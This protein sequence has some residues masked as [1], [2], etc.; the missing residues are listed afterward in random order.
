MTKRK[1][2]LIGMPWFW[3]YLPS[4]QLAIV[5]DVLGQ[6][7]VEADI[8]EFYADLTEATGIHVYKGIAN[9]SGYI[10]ELLFSQFYYE[11]FDQQ[12][13]D[14]RPDLGFSTKQVQDDIFLFATPVIEKFLGDCYVEADWGQYDCIC[15]S[16]TASQTAASMALAKR[17][18]ATHPSIPIIFGGSSCAGEMGRAMLRMC[19]EVDIVVHAEAEAVVPLL[20]EALSG[21]R[22]M[23]DVAGI[24][25]RE[26][27]AIRTNDKAGLHALSRK[28]GVLDFD[29]YF[30]RVADNKVLSDNGVWVPFESSRGCWYGEK[31][32]CT[33][34]GLNEIIQYRERG[35][36][37]LLDELK[38]YERK[39]GAK[40]FFAVDLIMPLSFFKG[41]LPSV[42]AAGKKWTIFYEIKSNMRRHEIEMLADSG[43]RWIQPGIESLD[44]DILRIMRK[45]VSAAHNIQT[46]R[47]T[48]EK[49]VT[50]SWNLITGFPRETAKSYF[51]MAGMF[52]KLHHLEPPVGLGDFEVHRFSP[53]F[54]N[55]E[56]MGIAL[57]GAYPTY[58]SVYP[59]EPEILDQLVYRFDYQLLAQ[60]DPALMDSKRVIHAAVETWRKAR[61]RG[62]DLHVTYHPDGTATLEDTR[63]TETS[64]IVRLE[65]EEASLYRFLDEMRPTTR[66]T[67]LFR[68]Q[69]PEAY[70]ALGGE[71]GVER[72]VDAWDAAELVL[73]VS[74]YV[75]ALAK[76]RVAAE[77]TLEIA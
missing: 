7:N 4:I 21:E 6:S 34:C 9:N 60:P 73:I 8:F 43:V 61:A 18:R 54:E 3:A 45:G 22:A 42:K 47:L 66:F 76:M 14:H 69:L 59:V 17:I 62:A 29:G 24:S 49:Q 46:L 58:R 56:A 41:F 15:F 20:L 37:G 16:L 13:N 2:A 53:F 71:D 11:D 19:G 40:N 1:F 5:K 38:H 63:A 67:D 44:D 74:G 51:D 72:L 28:R 52:H 23:A 25:W 75:Q 33:F 30:R 50:A 64:R 39:Y 10:G 31:A 68:A 48:K 36:E 35:S 55:P 27:P 77:R 26:G 65:Q 32:Q 57:K 12:F 70:A